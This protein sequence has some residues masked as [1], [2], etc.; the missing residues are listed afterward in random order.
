MALFHSFLHVY[1]RV[2]TNK[3]G[4]WR[5]SMTF[6]RFS[7]H[8]ARVA[9]CSGLAAPCLGA[10]CLGVVYQLGRVGQEQCDLEAWLAWL[11]G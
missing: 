5:I 7:G 4:T 10:S 1:Q 2:S 9:H 6:H 8:H 11:A 3:I